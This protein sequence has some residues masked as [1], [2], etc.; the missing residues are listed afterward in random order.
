MLCYGVLLHALLQVM[1][2]LYKTTFCANGQAQLCWLCDIIQSNTLNVDNSP[3]HLF[4]FTILFQFGVSSRGCLHCSRVWSSCNFLFLMWLSLPMLCP[5]VRP[6]IF[7]VL[8]FPYPV[9]VPGLLLCTRCMMPCKNSRLLPSCCI[10]WHF[11]CVWL[12]YIWTIVP[13]KLIDVIKVVQHLYF[14]P[15]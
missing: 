9:V 13:L 5:I 4:L 7:R 1:S 6:F 8:R 15:D 14:F 10:K 2:F 3:A 12:L 11:F